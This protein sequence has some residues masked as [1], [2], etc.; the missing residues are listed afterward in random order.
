MDMAGNLACTRV[1]KG[2]VATVAIEY[3]S[4][5]AP[6]K[7]GAVVSCYATIRGVG[8]SSVK[9]EVEA[10]IN[11]GSQKNEWIKVAEGGF[12]FVAIDD[13]GR[14]RAIPTA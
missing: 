3:I 6:I 11:A 13:N 4:F 12:V 5:L 8:R 10:W 1:A 7:I 2:K 14:T 9:V